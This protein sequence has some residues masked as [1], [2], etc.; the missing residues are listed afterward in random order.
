MQKVS[1]I[2][3]VL[4][5]LG[6]SSLIKAQIGVNFGTEYGFGIVAQAGSEEIK[7]EAGGGINPLLV[8]WRIT[9]IGFGVSSDDTEIKLY[10]P[11]VIG[12]R[13][14]LKLSGE[15]DENRLGLKLGI[16]YN[17]TLR[18][19]YGGG[20]AYD[21]IGKKNRIVISGGVMVFPKA[22]DELLD[23]LN[24]DEGTSFTQDEVSAFLLD[25]QPF[26]GLSIIW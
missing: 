8:V 24:E 26:V 4:S 21:M 1:L 19:G 6:L 22:D 11:G 25:I 2:L 16:N 3:I 5:L 7:L 18:T 15:E 14:N 10:F 13:L 20:L 9:T 12:A 17:T 23:R